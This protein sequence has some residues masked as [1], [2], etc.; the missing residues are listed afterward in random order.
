MNSNTGDHK[1]K[2]HV[3]NRELCG[4]H[5]IEN[6]FIAENPSFS[7]SIDEMNKIIKHVNGSANDG[8]IHGELDKGSLSPHC[9]SKLLI[10]TT[11]YQ[12]EKVR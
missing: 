8:K 12:P 10:N 2:I 7:I 6:L 11:T 3:Y 1:F 9:V 5:A 4:K